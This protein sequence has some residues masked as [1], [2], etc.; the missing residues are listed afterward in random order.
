[1]NLNNAVIV[2]KFG[3]TSMGNAA[4]I[5]QVAD[6]L[7]NTSGQKV[8]VVS[9]TS[10]TTDMLIQLADDALAGRPWQ[11]NLR[12]LK[13]KHDHIVED[14]KI[15]LDLEHYWTEITQLL[16]GINL[17]QELSLSANDRIMTFGER[18]SSQILAAHLN[19]Q[20][21]QAQPVD[22]YELVFTDNNFGE[23][24]VIFTKTNETVDRKL[25]P[26]LDRGIIPIVTGFIAQAQNGHYITL[27]RGGSDFTG[28]IIAAALNASGLQIWTDVDGILNSDPRLIPEATVLPQLSFGEASELAYF[29]AKVLHPKT[30]KP[31]IQKNIPVKILN[32]F[33][34][35][36]PGTVITNE[37]EQSLKSV[38]HK[39]GITIVNICGA[40]ILETHGFLAKIFSIF[41]RHKVVIDVVSTS[42]VSVSLTIDKPLPNEVLKELEEFFTVEIKENMAIVCLVGNG[43]KAETKILG[44]LF[45]NISEF[46]VS[47]VSQGASKRN[48]T[49]LVNEED[50]PK[51]VT[52]VFST[53]F[54]QN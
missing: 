18:I 32:T 34:T 36:A 41:A 2:A 17:I 37:E 47:M 10:G 54:H 28:A 27:G 8:A 52:R 48:I 19:S 5:R 13:N 20:K 1:M 53:F 12:K 40:E 35:D 44:D 29:G 43:I 11:E 7:K 23:G 38:T 6:I 14:L 50:A 46:D 49:F 21:L 26:L 9:A 24:N 39:K 15:N 4:A 16:Q 45:N 31:A 3:G 42:E 33:N 30:I 25:Q 51:I 22:A